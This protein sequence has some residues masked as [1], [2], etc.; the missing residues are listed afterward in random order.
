MSTTTQTNWLDIPG[1]A[2]LT[3]VRHR[4]LGAS[5]SVSV[6]RSDRGEIEINLLRLQLFI[7]PWRKR[8][9]KDTEDDYLDYRPAY[10]EAPD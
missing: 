2:E 4:R 7:V 9:V 5:A 10:T 8:G 1:L 6:K 3:L